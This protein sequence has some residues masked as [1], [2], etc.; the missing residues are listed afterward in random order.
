[1][2]SIP[3]KGSSSKIRSDICNL[4]DYIQ[5]TSVNSK[6]TKSFA[7]TLFFVLLLQLEDS[8][9]KCHLNQK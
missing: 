7:M 4:E 9:T 6:E 2:I 5:F 1:M 8:T 3:L